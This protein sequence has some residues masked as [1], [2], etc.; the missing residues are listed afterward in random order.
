MSSELIDRDGSGAFTG[1]KLSQGKKCWMVVKLLYQLRFKSSFT[2][3]LPV[4]AAIA[5]LLTLTKEKM[6]KPFVKP[7][8]SFINFSKISN[9]VNG[10]I[11][12]K[13]NNITDVMMS[14][15][16][17]LSVYFVNDYFLKF[18]GP[19]VRYFDTF[20]EMSSQ[21]ENANNISMGISV[22]KAE[23]NSSVVHRIDILT[24]DYLSISTPTY[25]RLIIDGFLRYLS[26]D[27]T[28]NIETS[29]MVSP[30]DGP[31]MF[32]G[33]FLAVLYGF[34]YLLVLP[35]LVHQILDILEGK[36]FLLIKM[37]GVHEKTYWLSVFIADCMIIVPYSLYQAILLYFAPFSKGTS[38]SL[39]FVFFFL[40]A[41]SLYLMIFSLSFLFKYLSNFKFVI[42]ILSIVIFQGT[43][44]QMSIDSYSSKKSIQNFLV[45][46]PF[47][48]YNYY[49]MNIGHCTIHDRDLG[50]KTLNHGF[51]IDTSVVMKYT[52]FSFLFYLGFSLLMILI[53]GGSYGLTPIR[54]L[55]IFR[56]SFWRSIFVDESPLLHRTYIDNH[57]F[58]K[59]SNLRK[60]YSGSTRVE[61]LKNIGFEIGA[62]ESIVLIGPNGSGK[63]TLI[64]TISGSIECDNGELEIYGQL[65]DIGFSKLQEMIGI[66]FQENILFDSLSVKEHLQ[67]F[68][69]IRGQ[70]F[71]DSHSQVQHLISAFELDSISDSTSKFLSG[72]QKRKLCIAIA[73]VGSPSFVILDEPTAGVDASA[74]QTIWKAISQFKNVTSLI[75]SHSLEE[76]ESVAS[77]IFVM[78]TGSIVFMG[79]PTELR[80]QYKCGYKV[81]LLGNNANFEGFLSFVRSIS[82]D[83]TIDHDKANSIVL[84]I[85][86]DFI[87]IVRSIYNR[88][89]EFGVED[90]N[91]NLESLEQ[92]LLRLIDAEDE[93]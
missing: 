41:L 75:S 5:L 53:R 37:S 54:I 93:E 87:Q 48:S 50:W 34:G 26:H 10:T 90:I 91:I 84:P 49:F 12:L 43:I 88:K 3:F 58:I 81:S 71:E 4:L 16:N 9:Y 13:E 65:S 8:V 89:S 24:N 67:F 73:F 17:D 68:S 28:V 19:P 30:Y 15:R 92:V 39:S 66:C 72:G 20:K 70:S 31:N 35:G 23:L 83:V 47:T 80:R 1:R 6:D 25:W 11:L 46:C 60:C 85:T 77:R 14:P 82:N 55:N 52:L 79:S 42:I 76:A 74:R 64:N 36:K 7:Y 40:S 29:D 51:I 18:G 56:G 45:F 44:I 27:I 59:V 69:R 57:P 61:A 86:D 22:P 33:V 63:S 38:V 78:K 32:F 21:I 62:S 2:I